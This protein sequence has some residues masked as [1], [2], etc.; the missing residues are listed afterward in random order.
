MG[1]WT[2]LFRAAEADMGTDDNKT[3]MF[4]ICLGIF[5]GSL[6]SFQIFGT[7]YPQYLPAVGFKTGFHIFRKGNIR[8]AL[9]CNFIVVVHVDQFAQTQGSCQGSRLR[10]H[11]FHQVPVGNNTVGI[12]VNNG[13]FR[14]IVFRCQHGLR[15]GKTHTH[16]KPVT[17]RAGRNIYAGSH[18]IFRMARRTASPL[19]ELFQFIQRQTVSC[20]M[21]HSIQQSGTMSRG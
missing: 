7:F 4:C 19:A 6:Q 17:Q 13:K 16:G 5:H 2:V 15:N 3:G 18:S 14:F 10:S 9:N 8:I 11:P 20:Q 1:G 12:V 21:Q